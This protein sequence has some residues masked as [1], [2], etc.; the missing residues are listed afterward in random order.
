MRVKCSD[1]AVFS[2]PNEKVIVKQMQATDWNAPE[3]KGEYMDDV[4]ARVDTMLGL[5]IRT[6]SAKMF[7]KDMEVAGLLT[8]EQPESPPV[9]TEDSDGI[10]T[11]PSS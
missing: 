1:G 6:G 10:H 11:D 9:A 8:F 5:T 7:L 4:A 3:R 2:G